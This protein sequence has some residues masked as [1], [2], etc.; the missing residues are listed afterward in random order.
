MAVKLD[1]AVLSLAHVQ[2]EYFRSLVSP[3][4]INS[5]II[6]TEEEARLSEVQLL[7]QGHELLSGSG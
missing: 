2:N 6:S 3:K 7:A 5:I 4:N 1:S